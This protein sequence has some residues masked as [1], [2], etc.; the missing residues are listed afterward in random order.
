MKIGVCIKQV[1]ATD[2]RVKVNDSATGIVTADVKWEMGAYE[3]FGLEE[4]IKLKEAGLASEV[5]VVSLGG[6]DTEPRMRD[7]L[8]RGADR[9]V[10]LDDPAFAG[11]DSLGVARILA[12]TARQQGF[13]LVFTGKQ[14]GDLD[15]GQVPAMMAE[16]LDWPQVL[17]VDK[18]EIEGGAFKAWRAVA[19]GARDIVAGTLP[20]VISCTKGLNTP[21][22]AT[23]KGI[24]MAK[25]KKIEVLGAAAIGL[26]AGSVG[27]GAAVVAEVNYALPPERK[28]GQVLTG[29]NATVV[30]ELVRLLR[31][32]A[33]VL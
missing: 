23:L 19:G 7:A 24:M 3:E 12:S 18:L 5:V 1:P 30:K 31:E 8:A 27:A 26:D 17:V 4:A 6:P 10:R 2:T 16:L 13:G 15:N 11:S 28:G 32:E 29:D 14:A 22:Y 21:R 25:R 33:K 20:A 9:G